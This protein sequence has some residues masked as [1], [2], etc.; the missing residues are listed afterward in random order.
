MIDRKTIL[1]VRA[2][3][4]AFLQKDINEG[5]FDHLLR[6]KF[7]FHQDL[8]DFL[9]V[10]NSSQFVRCKSCGLCDR[11]IWECNAL[12]SILKEAKKLKILKKVRRDTSDKYRYELIKELIE[13]MKIHKPYCIL[14]VIFWR[15]QS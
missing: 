9:D 11:D 3:F 10:I 1:K 2:Y 7:N 15:I 12:N 4:I 8:I 14:F 13:K 5:N 6:C